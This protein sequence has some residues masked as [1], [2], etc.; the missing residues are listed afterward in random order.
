M[1]FYSFSDKVLDEIL[2]KRMLLL[3]K[4]FCHSFWIAKAPKTS[5]RS[6]HAMPKEIF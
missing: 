1:D 3:Q 2:G 4:I 6:G 5:R